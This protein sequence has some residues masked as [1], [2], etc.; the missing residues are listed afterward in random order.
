[1]SIVIL[2]VFS[3]RVNAENAISELEAQSYNPKDMSILMKDSKEAKVIS[4]NTGAS[5]AEDTMK[6]A[7]TGAVVGGVAGFLAG[8]LLPGLGGFLIGGPI[9]AALGLTG[10]A[11]STVSGVA[12]GAVAGG[13]IGALTSTFDLTED[14]ARTYE[15]RINEGGIL[16]AVPARNGEEGEVK[17]IMKEF[18]AD[19]VRMVDSEDQSHSRGTTR[20]THMNDE[21]GAH[22][23][24]GAKGG[25]ARDE[26]LI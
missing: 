18:D 13:L 24:M 3:N 2:G 15:T 7:S 14:E 19:H 10:A 6:G 11:A 23:Q 4:D 9:G 1:M 8:T 5:V 16:V 22:H 25:T 21:S 17:D 12:T 20:S 26:E